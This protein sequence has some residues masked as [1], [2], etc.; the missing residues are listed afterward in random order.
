MKRFYLF[1][2]IIV[3]SLIIALAACG[4]GK[5]VTDPDN[6]NSNNEVN[7]VDGENNN[8][9][10]EDGISTDPVTITVAHPFGDDIHEERFGPI[11]EKLGHITIDSVYFDGSTDGLEELFAEDIV[12][13]IFISGS[14]DM[15]REYD[16]I[17]PVD[18]LMEKHDFDPEVIQPSLVQYL[19]SFDDQQRMIGFPDGV[20]YFALFYNKEVFDMFGEPYPDPE[21]PMTWDEVLDLSRRMTAERND[22]NYIG[23]EFHG[24]D[25]SAPINQFAVN[26]T[27]PESGEVLLQEKPEVTRYL[28]FVREYY[29]IPGM[30]TEE[31][32][33][34]CM[35]CNG[36]A[37]MSAAWHGIFLWG[38]LG[39]EPEEVE[40]IEIAPFPV[41]SD[42]PNTG[43]YLATTPMMISAYSEL[44]DE[45]FLV[46]KEYLSEENQLRMAKTVSAA[47]TTVYPTPL[48]SLGLEHPLY[49]GKNTKAITQLEAAVGE[50]RLSIRWD[51]YVDMNNAIEEIR[52]NNGDVPTILRELEEE[53]EAK[54]IEAKARE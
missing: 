17:I 24:N 32:T 25:M 14:V 40:Q 30:N 31:A 43:P 23:L 28:D 41:W 18:E 15:L 2:S 34:T 50:E 39:T 37:A 10:T 51:A 21:E 29:N 13:D 3:C 5:D 54:I 1:F 7:R 49:Q 20:A 6:S 27:D 9:D 46:L 8:E 33:T 19:E 52:E 48:E 47:P 45:A 38:E 44:Q 4:S 36:Q 26:Y 53:S 35:F 11:Q 12:P 16:A 42:M 22:V